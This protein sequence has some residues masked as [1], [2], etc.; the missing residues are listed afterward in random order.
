MEVLDSDFEN[1][2]TRRMD[3]HRTCRPSMFL[4]FV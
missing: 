2:H 1:I 3:W 4:T